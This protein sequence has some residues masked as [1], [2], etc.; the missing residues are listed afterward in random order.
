[1]TE[2]SHE[3]DQNRNHFCST[4]FSPAG[5]L[6]LLGKCWPFGCL[7][8]PREK[9]IRAAT[10]PLV[11]GILFG[12]EAYRSAALTSRKVANL[13]PAEPVPH[14]LHHESTWERLAALFFSAE[15]AIVATTG[16]AAIPIIELVISRKS[17]HRMIVIDRRAGSKALNGYAQPKS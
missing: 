14:Y 13:I 15:R 16:T 17:S 11:R 1:M 5:H 3:H 10:R 6:I 4:D 9:A 2:I 7:G 8:R 12:P